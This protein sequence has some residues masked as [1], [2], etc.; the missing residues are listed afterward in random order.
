MSVNLYNFDNFSDAI[1]APNSDNQT[2]RNGDN[3]FIIINNMGVTSISFISSSTFLFGSHA[4]LAD[5]QVGDVI[6]VYGSFNT[7]TQHSASWN[8]AVE[9][10]SPT[11]AAMNWKVV[12]SNDLT[13]IITGSSGG[14]RPAY[15]A[16]FR[17]NAAINRVSVNQYIPETGSNVMRTISYSGSV[18]TQ[19]KPAI[20]FASYTSEDFAV[21]IGVSY[22][23]S[24]E[25]G[26]G[27]GD[28]NSMTY[29]E[30][31]PTPAPPPEKFR[32]FAKIRTYDRTGSL[33][34]INVK[35]NLPAELLGINTALY[36]GSLHFE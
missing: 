28:V 24:A 9:G 4:I 31:P 7:Q 19:K 12:T 10:Q 20:A 18:Y 29:L 35:Y 5:K 21:E 30:R 6:L 14:P 1:V 16:L 22:Q 25:V 23:F 17:P 34:D 27:A 32:A 8:S 11:T 26:D 2:I 36:Y 33:R 3:Q 13:E 15:A